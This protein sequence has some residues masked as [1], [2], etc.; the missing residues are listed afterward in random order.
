MAHEGKMLPEMSCFS[1]LMQM[2]T[3][4]QPDSC[5]VVKES[6]PKG[7]HS[8]TS[9]TRDYVYREAFVR[10]LIIF[11]AFY[12]IVISIQICKAIFKLF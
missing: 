8:Q 5:F 2:L 1:M 7:I 3:G 11:L 9:I 10:E 12:R 4:P 6:Q